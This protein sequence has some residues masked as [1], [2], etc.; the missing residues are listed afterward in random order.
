MESPRKFNCTSVYPLDCDFYHLRQSWFYLVYIAISISG[1][2]ENA[3]ALWV[4]LRRFS[5]QRVPQNILVSLI[6]SDILL[7]LVL[8]IWTSSAKAQNLDSPDLIAVYNVGIGWV[9][10]IYQLLTVFSLQVSALSLACLGANRCLV[11]LK[12]QRFIAWRS[13]RRVHMMVI[14]TWLLAAITAIPLGIS[15]VLMQAGDEEAAKKLLLLRLLALFFL[16]FAI[17]LAFITI[18]HCLV[19]RRL[20][21]S[22]KRTNGRKFRS[23]ERLA[24]GVIFTFLCCTSPYQV[25]I[26]VRILCWIGTFPEDH[27]RKWEII[28]LSDVAFALTSLNSCI[29]PLIYILSCSK[30]RHA[31]TSM[32]SNDFCTS[33]SDT[34]HSTGVSPNSFAMNVQMPT[35]TT[36]S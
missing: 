33:P 32:L 21:D 7:L 34:D 14:S 16:G 25:Y 23:S 15:G 8:L 35:Q 6:A 19:A 17:P 20:H 26:F 3:V 13:P 30:F 10:V 27:L 1:L 5:L 4:I 2:L 29:N 22:K 18:A 24:Q 11:L 12:N 28:L 36:G 9:G 31:L